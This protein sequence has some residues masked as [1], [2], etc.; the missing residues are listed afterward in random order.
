MILWPAFEMTKKVDNEI[1]SE[2]KNDGTAQRLS[3]THTHKRSMFDVKIW[4]FDHI[5]MSIT[6]IIFPYSPFTI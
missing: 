3:S 4:T 2:H 5:H 1:E 6:C